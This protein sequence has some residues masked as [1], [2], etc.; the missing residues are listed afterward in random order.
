MKL[1][2]AVLRALPDNPKGDPLEVAR[3]A[4]VMAAKKTSE[5]IPMCH[6]LLLKHVD[7]IIKPERGGLRILSTVTTTGATGV[8]MEALTAASVAALTIYDMTKALDKG[9]EIREIHLL[10]KTGGKS[11]EWRRLDSCRCCDDSDSAVE[12]TR[13]DRSG[14][15][16]ASRCEA[17]GWTVSDRKVIA[18]RSDQDCP[19]AGRALRFRFARV[20]LTTGGTGVAARD[21]TP[22][23]TRAVIEREVPGLP[24]L[25]RAD[26][27]STREGP[28]SPAASRACAATH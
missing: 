18:G 17:L 5:L 15:A 2:P 28:F 12:G 11:G 7:V 22:E 13:E 10:E 9:I 19:A 23:A 4:G 6:P 21:V 8:E 26:G 27:C 20:V 24:E 1:R 25:I 16:V 3:I 14:P